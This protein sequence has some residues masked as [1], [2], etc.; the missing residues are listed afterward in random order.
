MSDFEKQRPE[1]SSGLFSY[2]KKTKRYWLIPLLI[3]AV[4]VAVLV[5]LGSSVLA[6]FIYPLF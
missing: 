4:V 6:P 2:L 5:G 3:A 1:K